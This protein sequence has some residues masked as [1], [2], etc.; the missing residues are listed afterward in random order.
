[1]ARDNRLE[2]PSAA[3]TS[4]ARKVTSP[5]GV[6]AVTPTMRPV[7]SSRTGPVTGVSSSR[8]APAFSAWRTSSSSKSDRGRTRPYD[9]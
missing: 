1:M 8:W 5:S 6:F 4:G 2:L 7:R 3:T 9:G